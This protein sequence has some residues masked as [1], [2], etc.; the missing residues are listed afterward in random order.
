MRVYFRD[1]DDISKE[2]FVRCDEYDMKDAL[3]LVKVCR[4]VDY[5]QPLVYEKEDNFLIN[6]YKFVNTEFV[7]GDAEI[8][9]IDHINIY[10]ER[11]NM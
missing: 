6:M 7:L 1:I 8:G 3:N 9:T 2:S 4:N 11:T 5:F 10:I